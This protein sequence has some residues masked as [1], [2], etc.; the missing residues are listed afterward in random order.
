MACFS[1]RMY[2]LR[3]E[4]HLKKVD[5]ANGTGLS[6]SS[7]TKYENGERDNPTQDILIILGD[8]FNVS[9]DYLSGHSNIKDEDISSRTLSDI[10]G[11]LNDNYKIQLVTYA[12]FILKEQEDGE[13][14]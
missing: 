9:I 13:H 12:K 10:F 7:I 4:R 3:T 11:K 8:F 14:I 2:E 6:R 5:V 1:E